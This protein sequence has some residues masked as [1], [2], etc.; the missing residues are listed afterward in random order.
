MRDG[1]LARRRSWKLVRGTAFPLLASRHAGISEGDARHI[2]K[3]L[4]IDLGR[5]RHT[6]QARL[7]ERCGGGCVKE[8]GG[9]SRVPS[10]GAP[11][12][13]SRQEHINHVIVSRSCS[14]RQPCITSPITAIHSYSNHAKVTMLRND[15]TEQAHTM[16]PH[17]L[18][19]W[20]IRSCSGFLL[21]RRHKPWVRLNRRCWTR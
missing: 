1:A 20:F 13:Q 16:L 18:T 5:Q 10:G 6:Q 8:K 9:R 14:G 12:T 2:L 15:S 21:V 4:V 3:N 7:C 17:P 11:E 19:A